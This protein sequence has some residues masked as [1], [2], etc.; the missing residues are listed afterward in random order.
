MN[1]WFK[2]YTFWNI[3][4]F[5]FQKQIQ[6]LGSLNRDD[7]YDQIFELNKIVLEKNTE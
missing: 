2:N 4:R 6:N 7:L 3:K 1:I 5:K